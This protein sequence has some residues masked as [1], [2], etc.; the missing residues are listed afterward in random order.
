MKL[1]L[2]FA[3]DWISIVSLL[4]TIALTISIYVLSEENRKQAESRA[5]NNNI[6][7]EL[8]EKKYNTIRFASDFFFL[9][10][11]ANSR[12]EEIRSKEGFKSFDCSYIEETSY[13]PVVIKILNLYERVAIASE[14]GYIDF[15]IVNTLRGQGI[16]EEFC[17]YKEFIDCRRESKPLWMNFEALAKRIDSIRAEECPKI[18]RQR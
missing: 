9:I 6:E 15:E 11:E 5:A 12:L 16:V 3:S 4:I 18:S 10:D 14:N 1:Q 13:E 8:R 2:R 7:A 17:K